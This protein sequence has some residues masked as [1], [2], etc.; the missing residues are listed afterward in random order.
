M[1][2]VRII[3]GIKKLRCSKCKYWL[4]FEEFSADKATSTGKRAYC[5]CCQKSYNGKRKK[6]D[7]NSG[8]IGLYLEKCS[9]CGD[10]FT[11]KASNAS[12]CSKKCS[13]RWYYEKSEQTDT[14][15]LFG[16]SR[17]ILNIKKMKN[18]LEEKIIS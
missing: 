3:N 10:S 12:F 18:I 17:V 15:K 5:K 7:Y 11:T 9:Q 2:E 13:R 14:G 16:R 4:P 6:R 8:L 1:R